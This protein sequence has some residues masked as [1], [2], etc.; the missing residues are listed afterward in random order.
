MAVVNG[1]EKRLAAYKCD[2]NLAVCLKLVRFPEDIEDEGI[3]FH[4]EYTHQVFGDEEVAFGYKDLQIQL[5]YTAGNLSTLFQVKYS[6]KVSDAYES[7]ESDDVEGKIREIIPAGFT[8]NTDDFISLLEKEANFK[9][10]GT[11]LH[12]YL[13]H[14]E[15]SGELTYQIY[16]ADI[17]CPAFL[18]YHKRL[19]TFIM[20]YIETASFIDTDDDRWDFF[21]L[22]ML[23]MPPFQGEGHGA[24]LLETVHRFYCSLPKVQ[25]ITAED[26]SENYVKL[27][28]YVLAKLCQGLPSFAADKL[29]LGFSDEMIKE[30]QEKQK[31][32][33]KHA[34]RVYEILRLRATDMSDREKARAYRLEVKK[35]LFGPYRKNQRELAKMRKCL[36]PEELVSHMCQTNTQTQH[37]EL[38]KSYQ[39]LV[40]DYRRVIDRLAQA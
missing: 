32:N 40:D 25:D 31:I 22:Q 5:F 16:K 28:D 35:R 33:K 8:C 24:Q 12:S 30:A 15:V 39:D 19:Q 3:K 26:P 23:I 37:E 6:A 38:E 1:I 10:F 4:P 11:L 13:L 20:W 14:S 17:T 27:R 7:V 9:P 29:H 34:R 36:R 21:L 2:T 18:D